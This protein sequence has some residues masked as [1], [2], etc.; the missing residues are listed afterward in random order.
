MVQRS[1]DE[2]F[3][4]QLLRF[5]PSR[6]VCGRHCGSKIQMGWVQPIVGWVGNNQM[7][8]IECQALAAF[9]IFTGW[10]NVYSFNFNINSNKKTIILNKKTILVVLNKKTTIL[11]KK[12]INKKNKNL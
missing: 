10:H 1:S 5:G 7:C 9:T 3:M 8:K 11:N 12:T 2:P 6:S 4:M